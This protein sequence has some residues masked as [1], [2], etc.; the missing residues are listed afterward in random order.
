[1]EKDNERKIR[2]IIDGLKC[3]KDFRCYKSG[4]EY[5]CK[6]EDIGQDTFLV[7]HEKDSAGCKFSVSFGKGHFCKCPLR[8]YI[9]KEFNK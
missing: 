4:F 1:M 5:L 6:A 9:A 7:C 3:P 8:I 2:E